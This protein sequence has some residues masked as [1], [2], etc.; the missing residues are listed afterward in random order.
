[1]DQE[2]SDSDKSD[3]ST[4]ADRRRSGRIEDA[5]PELVPLMRG[6]ATTGADD[7][8]IDPIE[9]PG[10]AASTG[11]MLGVLIGAMMWAAMIVAG[12]V[13]YLANAA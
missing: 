10:L 8:A 7:L 11:I 6:T 4:K 5:S 13:V 3:L 1:M 12:V 9:P 2:P